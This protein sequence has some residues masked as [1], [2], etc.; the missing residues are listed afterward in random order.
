MS[1]YHNVKI[2]QKE[3]GRIDVF[4]DDKELKGVTHLELEADPLGIPQLTLHLCCGFLFGFRCRK[5]AK[6]Y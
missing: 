6:E 4:L 1:I 2:K 5:K 3:V